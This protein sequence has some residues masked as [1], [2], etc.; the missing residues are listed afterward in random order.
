MP[1]LCIIT[2]LQREANCLEIPGTGN[3]Y[4]VL[5]AGTDVNRILPLIKQR[6]SNG[7]RGI[8]SFGVAGALNPDLNPGDLVLAN[9][10]IGPEG[11]TVSVDDCWLKLLEHRLSRSTVPHT[12]RTAPLFGSPKIVTSA[13]EKGEIFRITG[14]DAVDMESYPLAQL[15]RDSATRFVAI[16][17]IADTATHTLPTAAQ[18][19]IGDSGQILI[20]RVL[21]E[22]VK[23][24]LQLPQL[25]ALSKPY[26]KALSTLRGVA[27]LGGVDFGL[28]EL[29]D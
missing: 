25:L 8:V 17:A 11:E 9:Q 18:H 4:E 7:C 1:R 20:S 24:P 19:A 14:A 27:T 6:I 28:T 12:H 22:L 2:G 13:S 23:H 15:C 5:Q 21:W 29:V 26:G 10:I 3:D 16:R